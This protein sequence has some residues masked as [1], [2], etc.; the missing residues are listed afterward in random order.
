[1]NRWLKR[2]YGTQD[3]VR[4]IK[5]SNVSKLVDNL[6]VISDESTDLLRF[7]FNANNN[8]ITSKDSNN[9]YF[10]LKQKRYG[11]PKKF[12][13]KKKMT[14]NLANDVSS[15]PV[16]S[17]KVRLRVLVKNQFFQ[18]IADKDATTNYKFFKKG[19]VHN[20][21]IPVPLAKRILRTR[22]TLV[23]PA[24]VNI[25]AITNSYDVVHA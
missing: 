16:R 15:T 25:T 14:R 4:V 19:K 17:E 3:P 24:H 8:Y 20:E 21:T 9:I 1:M 11:V 10:A 13:N 7:R 5:Y 6:D 2:G 23:L 22:R 12:A 18:T